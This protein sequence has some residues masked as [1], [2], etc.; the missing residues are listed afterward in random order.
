LGTRIASNQGYTI[1]E[2]AKLSGLPESPLRYYE[3]IGKIEPIN[4]DSSSKHRVY[5]VDDINVIVSIACLSAIGMSL[6]DMRKYLKNRE[7]GAQAADDQIGLLETQQQR[8]SQRVNLLE[9]PAALCANKDS[10]LARCCFR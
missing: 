4:R 1:L 3:S 2:A 8:L 5:S 9:A 10:Q 7:L 6:N